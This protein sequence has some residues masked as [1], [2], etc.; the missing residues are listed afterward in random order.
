[1]SHVAEEII[2]QPQLWRRA[3]ALHADQPKTLPPAGTRVAIAGA[4]TS[5]YMAEAF[6]TLRERSGQGETDAF[7][8]SEAL[9]R[10]YDA[11]IA[12]SR[13][14]TTTEVLRYLAD[15]PTDTRKLAIT[16]TPDSPILDLVDDAVVLD[17]ADEISVVQTR[18]ATTALAFLR[19]HLGDAIEPLAEAA[20]TAV[21]APLPLDPSGVRQFVF[22]GTGFGAAIAREAAL[23]LREA[24]GAWT[25]AYP[26]TEFRHGP[27]S[28]VESESVV[29]ALSRVPHDLQEAIALTGA[30]FVQESRDPMVE[31]IMVQRTA[32]QLA[33]LRGRDP[34]HPRHL[35]R[36]VILTD[37][38]GGEP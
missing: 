12:L 2:T 7:T 23:K 14:G 8:P 19:A 3:A 27:I 28:A 37:G 15:L 5:L 20:E 10:R 29:W 4:G 6:A 26:A 33:T 9:P 25:E 24:A 17:F 38:G 16:G 32:V 21:A 36:S 1:M 34:D 31:L 30:R 22:L 11:V 13:S 35:S 18:F